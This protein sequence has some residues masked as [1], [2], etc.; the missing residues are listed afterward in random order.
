[1]RESMNSTVSN[2]GFCLFKVCDA[3]KDLFI[4]ILTMVK[5]NP[6]GHD[7]GILNDALRTY[8]GTHHFFPPEFVTTSSTLIDINKNESNSSVKKDSIIVHQTLVHADLKG[9]DA[10]H[11]KLSE[12]VHHFNI[13][14]EFI[15]DY[16]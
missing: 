11:A 6:N 12:Y 5:K 10:I 9:K 7:Q 16:V 15:Y 13:P 1:M 4:R 2:F 3:N 14:I 8:S